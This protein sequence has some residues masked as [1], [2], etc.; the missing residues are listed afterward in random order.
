[1]GLPDTLGVESLAVMDCYY[2]SRRMMGG[3][4]QKDGDIVVIY[5]VYLGSWWDYST[6]RQYYGIAFA[7]IE[8]EQRWIQSYKQ[9][10]LRQHS[11]SAFNLTLPSHLSR[12]FG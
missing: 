4:G 12:H 8:H 3:M 2:Y 10:D 7:C 9:D 11:I 1:M 6:R 5:L